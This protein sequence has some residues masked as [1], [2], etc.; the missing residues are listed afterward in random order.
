MKDIIRTI[1]QITLGVTFLILVVH[2]LDGSLLGRLFGPAA[3]VIIDISLLINLVWLGIVLFFCGVAIIAVIAGITDRLVDPIRPWYKRKYGRRKAP[4]NALEATQQIMDVVID[5]SIDKEEAFSLLAGDGQQDKP[6]ALDKAPPAAKRKRAS[7]KRIYQSQHRSETDAGMVCYAGKWVTRSEAEEGI[8]LYDGKWMTR[9]EKIEAI[10]DE[11][12]RLREA[13]MVVFDGK[14]MTQSEAAS[15]LASAERQCKSKGYTPEKWR[16]YREA[17]LHQ[18]AP[19]EWGTYVP[20]FTRS[21][22]YHNGKWEPQ[23]KTREYDLRLELRTAE[24]LMGG[25]SEGY[26][27][28]FFIAFTPVEWRRLGDLRAAVREGSMG[29]EEAHRLLYE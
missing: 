17:L 1:I 28:D 14:W 13:G 19:D 18:P 9:S 24:R 6:P 4:D 8:G 7:V 22:V 25:D 23:L 15:E 10:R 16:E 3:P 2:L 26:D 5:G 20:V 27:K 12:R 21:M 11:E 29:I